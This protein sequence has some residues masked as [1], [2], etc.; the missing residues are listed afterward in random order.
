[1]YVYET[2]WGDVCGNS[3][4]TNTEII[5]GKEEALESYRMYMK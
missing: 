4:E 3:S 5:I 2:W 1:M